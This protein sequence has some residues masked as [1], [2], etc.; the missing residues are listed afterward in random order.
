MTDFSW[1]ETFK[2]QLT[3]AGF[4]LNKLSEGQA[5][6]ILEPREGPENFYCD[7]E[8]NFDQALSIW[9]KKLKDSGLD[10]AEIKNAFKLNFN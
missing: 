4:D 7:G 2:E 9:V 3:N 6:L 1:K 10:N 8:I 5:A